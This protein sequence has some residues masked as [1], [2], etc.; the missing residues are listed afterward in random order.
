MLILQNWWKIIST[1]FQFLKTKLPIV[2]N[3]TTTLHVKV[4]VWNALDLIKITLIRGLQG[5]L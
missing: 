1:S 5:K 4:I 3:I 2:Y